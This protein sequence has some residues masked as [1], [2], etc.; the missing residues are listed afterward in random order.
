[1]NECDRVIYFDRNYSLETYL[2]SIKR[3]HRIGQTN[4][5]ITN[6]L[7]LDNSL[8]VKQHAMLQDK[9]KL[10]NTAFDNK[11]MSKQDIL[12]VFGSSK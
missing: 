1:L 4:N 2:Q 10:N 9:E 7:I 12:N 8:E 3:N 6:L 5:V 11:V